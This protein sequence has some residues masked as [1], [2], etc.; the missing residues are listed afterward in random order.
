[1]MSCPGTLVRFLTYGFDSF[2]GLSA[3]SFGGLLRFFSNSFRRLLGF[4]TDGF[5]SFFDFLPCFLRPMLNL[6]DCSFLPK[7]G[8]RSGCEQS[9]NQTCYFHDFLLLICNLYTKERIRH[10]DRASHGAQCNKRVG[11]FGRVSTAARGKHKGLRWSR[12]R[13]SGVRVRLLH[14]GEGLSQFACHYTPRDR[15]DEAA[16][17]IPRL[18]SEAPWEIRQH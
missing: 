7:H 1:V 11:R 8:Q 16:E 15:S 3:N 12:R 9:D 10:C 13:K 14:I 5:D 6:L 17:R 2:V 4:L 18:P